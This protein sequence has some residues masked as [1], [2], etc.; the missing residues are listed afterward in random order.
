ME[1]QQ[2]E[3]LRKFAMNAYKMLPGNRSY[4]LN[5]T[6]LEGMAALAKAYIHGNDGV[7]TEKEFGKILTELGAFVP[8]LFQ[9]KPDES[10]QPPKIPTDPVSGERLPNPWA[11]GNENLAAQSFVQ[12]TDPE[13][14]EYFKQAASDPWKFAIQWQDKESK[15]ELRAAFTY[16]TDDHK[17]NPFATG[18]LTEQGELQKRDPVLAEIYKREAQP[19]SLPFVPG[20]VK[21]KIIRSLLDEQDWRPRLELLARVFPDEYGRREIVPQV[22]QER[23]PTLLK[24][25]LN[26]NGKT[27]EE[28]TNF[29]I[30]DDKSPPPDEAK[31]PPADNKDAP[32]RVPQV[33]AGHCVGWRDR[34]ELDDADA[35]ELP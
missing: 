20:S 6:A 29:P 27:L 26:T 25:V 18:R 22:E 17:N 23:P 15:R 32:Q 35:E 16:T 7:G 19:V 34:D 1:N 13:L 24:V 14:A 33:I 21:V 11:K 30:I 28:I 10:K 12:K 5:E 31:P 3:K 9:P 4:A 2:L 8:N